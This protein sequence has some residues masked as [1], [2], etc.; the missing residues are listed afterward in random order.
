MPPVP[1]LK[2]SVVCPVNVPS[3]TVTVIV[4]LPFAPVPV[5]VRLRLVPLPPNDRPASARIFA[6]E[7][8]PVRV[9]VAG[10]LS[11]SATVRATR[12]LGLVSE[13][14]ALVPASTVTVTVGASSTG[15]TVTFTVA[16]FE[17]R[18]PSNAR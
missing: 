13:R 4:E 15:L 14:H 12:P 11:T 8:T 2:R 3:D 16:R 7:L 1:T 5:A 17:V 18:A 10:S 6:T 9:R